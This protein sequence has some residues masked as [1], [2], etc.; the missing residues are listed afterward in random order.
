LFIIKKEKPKRSV[1][2]SCEKEGKLPSFF[3]L[4]DIYNKIKFMTANFNI[5]QEEKNRILEMHETS[6][7]KHY[8]NEQNVPPPISD[9]LPGSPAYN[10]NKPAPAQPA[11]A[12]P[13]PAQ[14]DPKRYQQLQNYY[15][16]NSKN[17]KEIQKMLNVKQDGY[18][19]KNTYAAMMNAIKNLQKTGTKDE[20][21]N[22]PENPATTQTGK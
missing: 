12:Q 9:E 14:I 16:T 5:S 15:S 2:L 7:K 18:L 3:I 6:T 11:P 13:A 1:S 21:V 10:A 19:G 4:F 20:P 8:L 22:V 17:I